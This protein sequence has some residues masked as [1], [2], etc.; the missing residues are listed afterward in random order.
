MRKAG[1]LSCVEISQ[2]TQLLGL[3]IDRSINWNSDIDIVCKRLSKAIYA[4][5]M[6][7]RVVNKHTLISVYYAYFHS[8]LTYGLEIWGNAA[9]EYLKNRVF[10]LQKKAV[11]ILSNL[12]AFDS[13]REAF[14]ELKILPFPALYIFQAVM[15]VKKYPQ[16]F[17]DNLQAHSYNTRNKDLYSIDISI[18]QQQK[19][20]GCTILQSNYIIISLKR[21][22]MRLI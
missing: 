10:K 1:T 5:R 2:N 19:R 21:C 7:K 8:I 12:G 3:K 11:R 9:A 17:L 4:L 6:L 22:V 13:C 15:F 16:Y 18:E 14:V 20:K